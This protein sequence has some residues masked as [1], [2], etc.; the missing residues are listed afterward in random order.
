MNIKFAYT[1]FDGDDMLYIDLIREF[2]IKNDINPLNPE[3]ALGYYAATHTLKDSKK[4]VMRNCFGLSSLCNEFWIFTRIDLKNP[5]DICKLSEGVL[6]EMIVWD[7]YCRKDKQRYNPVFRVVNLNDLLEYFIIS[8]KIAKGQKV[9]PHSLNILQLKLTLAEYSNFLEYQ[10]FKE[11]TLFVAE[12]ENLNKSIFVDIDDKYF[13]YIDWVRINLYQQNNVPI[14][15]Q[16]II[17]EKIYLRYDKEALYKKAVSYLKLTSDS[18]LKIVDSRMK[19]ESNLT[20]D[21]NVEFKILK[22]FG[23]PKFKEIDDWA[24][25]TKE[26]IE[27]LA[28]LNSI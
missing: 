23:L 19:I 25:T 9:L 22:D 16:C 12:Y 17:P 3:H 13:K 6:S 21:S 4:E 11:L 5:S 7:R 26:K 2:L 24:I 20:S 1:A 8:E 10:Y 15:P 18:I 28:V 27:N 14:I